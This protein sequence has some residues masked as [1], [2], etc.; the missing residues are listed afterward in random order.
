MKIPKY[1]VNRR[2]LDLF[3]K[4]LGG[5]VILLRR[6]GEVQYVHQ[7]FPQRPRADSRRKDAPRHLVRFVL[8]VVRS[9][10]TVAAN[11]E[12]FSEIE[13]H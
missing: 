9:I 4:R 12:H 2:D 6:T 1:G 3:F 5:N 13:E 8:D 10:D 7:L 11:D